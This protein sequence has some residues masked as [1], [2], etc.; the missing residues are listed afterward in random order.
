MIK[1]SDERAKKEKHEGGE[2]P[3]DSCRAEFR[4]MIV[5]STQSSSN[6]PADRVIFA[7]EENRS[8]RLGHPEGNLC[9]ASHKAAPALY[10]IVVAPRA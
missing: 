10:K 8:I 2:T 4:A 1:S 6:G 7:E 5:T 9:M 3:G